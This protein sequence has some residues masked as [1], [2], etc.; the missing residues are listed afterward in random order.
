M[1]YASLEKIQG[2]Q[3]SCG[4]KAASHPGVTGTGKP[5]LQTSCSGFPLN[6]DITLP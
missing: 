6:A 5:I 3:S 4:I 1:E 2:N